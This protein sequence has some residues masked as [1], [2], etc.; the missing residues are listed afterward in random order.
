MK[1]VAVIINEGNSSPRSWNGIRIANG[2][3]DVN[4]EV[5]VI[6]FDE[7]VFC[8]K[9]GQ[10]PQEGLEEQALSKKLTELAGLGVTVWACG[11][12]MQAKG[13]IKEE[14]TEGVSECCM[15]DVCNSIKESDNVL[16]F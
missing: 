15:M 7:A 12:C 14:L 5:I 9:K 3:L 13:L 16:V 4:V 1:K 6:L 10:L 11:T 2:L 8:A